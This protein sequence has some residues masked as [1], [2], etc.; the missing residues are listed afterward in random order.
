MW[1]P[2][3]AIDAA[4]ATPQWAEF[5]RRCSRARVFFEDIRRTGA[6]FTATAFTTRKVAGDT[7]A[8]QKLSTG[9]GGTPEIA[10]RDALEQ[11]GVTVYGAAALLT[12]GDDLD[13]MIGDPAAA[14]AASD[15]D[16]EGMLG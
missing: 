4:R 13:A 8:H 3:A 1:M 2:D 15:D 16:F 6:G 10:V 7:W 12:A 5:M 9:E 11:S 14:P